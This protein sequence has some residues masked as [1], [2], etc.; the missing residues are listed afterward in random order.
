M[1]LQEIYIN[2][3]LLDNTAFDSV[4]VLIPFLYSP[5][6]QEFK[7]KESQIKNLII[8]I[9]CEQFYEN[10]VFLSILRLFGT[11]EFFLREDENT[12]FVYSG[13]K[14]TVKCSSIGLMYSGYCELTESSLVFS[15]NS[16]YIT[17]QKPD[18]ED[19]I[20]VLPEGDGLYYMNLDKKESESSERVSII[21]NPSILKKH[22]KW[23]KDKSNG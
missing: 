20:I 3:L 18:C 1:N 16:S 15:E 22:L 12:V 4:F 21:G 5:V 8:E 7:R 6:L 2:D 10:E 11:P 9:N 13:K 14:I 19:S 23:L 17:I